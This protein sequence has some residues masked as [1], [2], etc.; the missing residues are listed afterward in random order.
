ML[1][2]GAVRIDGHNRLLAK[3]D[4]RLPVPALS[5]VSEPI[6]QKR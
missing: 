5:D 3:R 1:R 2:N 6:L 4:G